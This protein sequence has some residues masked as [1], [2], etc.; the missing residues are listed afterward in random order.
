MGCEVLALP[1]WFLAYPPIVWRPTHPYHTPPNRVPRPW[2][3]APQVRRWRVVRLA[4]PG[5]PGP[6][7]PATLQALGWDLEL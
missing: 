1:P 4:E 5:P 7:S 3:R 2:H 6:L